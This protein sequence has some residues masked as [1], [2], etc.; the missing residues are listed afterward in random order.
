[1]LL[2]IKHWGINKHGSLSILPVTWDAER[3]STT[4][5]LYALWAVFQPCPTKA[6]SHQSFR[7][8][9]AS[10][11][12]PFLVQSGRF[13]QSSHGKISQ[14]ATSCFCFLFLPYWCTLGPSVLG[15]DSCPEL[16]TRRRHV[17]QH[18]AAGSA[19]GEEKTQ[20]V[21]LIPPRMPVG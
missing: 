5:R 14:Q 16:R 17:S 7:G 4:L 10:H 21:L 13:S 1:M 11:F 6:H 20:Q 2:T 12:F 15:Q 18:Q 19:T 3:P 8:T 9:G